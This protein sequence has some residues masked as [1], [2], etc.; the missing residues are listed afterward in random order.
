[1]EFQQ[2]IYRYFFDYYKF[3]RQGMQHISID[4]DPNEFLEG[5]IRNIFLS[6]LE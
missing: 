4:L 3:G 6:K 1:M 5:N 2:G